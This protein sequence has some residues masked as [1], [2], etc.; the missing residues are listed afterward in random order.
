M[1]D[2]TLHNLWYCC[3]GP[4]CSDKLGQTINFAKTRSSFNSPSTLYRSHKIPLFNLYNILPLNFQYCKSVCTIKHDVS[5]NCLSAN[6]CNLFLE[7]SQV[8][9]YNTTFSETG[10]LYIKYSRTNHYNIHFLDLLQEFG[11][12]FLKVSEY[13]LNTNLR[14]LYISSFKYFRIEGYLCWHTYFN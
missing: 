8:D 13:F 2:P 4:K 5:N 1:F 12:V 10:R 9:S 11:T 14:L 6:S 7:P 3:M